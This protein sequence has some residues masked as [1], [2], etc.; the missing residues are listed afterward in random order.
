MLFGKVG[1]AIFA[2]K[3]KLFNVFFTKMLRWVGSV[4]GWLLIGVSAFAFFIVDALVWLLTFWW[5]KRLWILQRYSIVWALSY[6]WVNPFW[7]INF[8]GKENVRKGQTY[9]I[10]SNHQSAMDIVLLYRLWMHFKW[11]AKKELFRI[12]VIGWNLWLNKH[13]AINRNSVKDALKMMKQAEEHLKMRSSVLIF[14][15]GT[16]SVDGT[17]KRFRDGAFVLA[18]KTGYPILPVVLNGTREVVS[19]DSLHIKGKQILTLR[20]LPEIT[21]DFY[22]EKNVNELAAYVQKIITKEHKSIA[23]EYYKEN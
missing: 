1:W 17:V 15:E 5:D 14:P 19:T 20:I 6:I 18:Q 2:H 23:P 4:F 16:R 22:A 8:S 13:I 12:P 10:V 7:K 21:S 11:V 9:V 3:Y